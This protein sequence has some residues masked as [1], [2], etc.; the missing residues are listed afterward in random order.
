M[1]HSK[2]IIYIK[3]AQCILSLITSLVSH[4]TKQNKGSIISERIRKIKKIKFGEKL[5]K[6]EKHANQIGVSVRENNAHVGL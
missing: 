6:K 4:V 1:T 3:S 5:E 2:Q